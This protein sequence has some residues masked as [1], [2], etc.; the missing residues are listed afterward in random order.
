MV[1]NYFNFGQTLIEAILALSA[2]LIVLSAISVA[3][4]NSVSN[5]TFVKNQDKTNKYAQEGIEYIKRIKETNKEDFNDYSGSYCLGYTS[6]VLQNLSAGS[7][8]TCNSL[9]TGFRHEAAFVSGGCNTG[10][11]LGTRVTVTVSWAS[12][13]CASG[14][15][16]HKAELSTCFTDRNIGL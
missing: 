11:F 1:K 4:V 14:S 2:L 7:G 16:C 6:G 8:A 3:V 10:G 9:S 12:G 13:K 5:S 15:L